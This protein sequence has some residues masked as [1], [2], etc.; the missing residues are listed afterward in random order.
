M[1]GVKGEQSLWYPY[2]INEMEQ[3]I[4]TS[5]NKDGN[6]CKKAR[7][8]NGEL[9]LAVARYI[10]RN[11][12]ATSRV[13]SKEFSVTVQ[14]I[15]GSLRKIREKF[16]AGL[17]VPGLSDA[18]AEIL[19]MAMEA[20]D[21]RPEE[22]KARMRE[23]KDLRGKVVN[24]LREHLITRMF[25]EESSI[26]DIAGATG[27]SKRNVMRVLIKTGHMGSRVREMYASCHGV[28]RI[29][30][31]TG[32]RVKEVRKILQGF[33]YRLGARAEQ[34]RHFTPPEINRRKISTVKPSRPRSRKE[35]VRKKAT[36]SREGLADWNRMHYDDSGV[37]RLPYG[38]AP[39]ADLPR[40]FPSAKAMTIQSKEPGP[41]FFPAP[42]PKAECSRRG[43]DRI[44]Y[45]RFF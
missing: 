1:S 26:P 14:S 36:L 5:E 41:S 32:L 7:L 22:E 39:P 43:R 23:E 10:I 25:E 24:I 11:S 29:A 19:S 12:S 31:V 27:V 6:K 8:K 17:A 45:M 30:G 16:Q 38:C 33:G 42:P 40:K 18:E 4:S 28:A 44:G 20:R 13:M 2:V 21:R 34:I 35:V 15:N 3:N 9:L 37:L